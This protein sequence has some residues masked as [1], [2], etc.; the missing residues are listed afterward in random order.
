MIL[1]NLLLIL[2]LTIVGNTVL[3]LVT[4]KKQHLFHSTAI[5]LAIAVLSHSN[6]ISVLAAP[7]SN[8]IS[9]E[10]IARFVNRNRF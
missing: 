5:L 10:A 2:S 7:D 6:N 1:T 8:F 4:T 3:N 9:P